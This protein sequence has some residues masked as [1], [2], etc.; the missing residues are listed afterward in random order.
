MVPAKKS[1]NFFMRSRSSPFPV[2]IG[3]QG[4]ESTARITQGVGPF[5][6]GHHA[7]V[8]RFQVGFHVSGFRGASFGV[9][10]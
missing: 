8:M 1:L 9:M 3:A 2:R 4:S 10:E 6:T 7:P 5:V